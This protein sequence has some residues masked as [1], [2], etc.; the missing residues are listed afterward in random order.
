[1]DQPATI[2]QTDWRRKVWQELQPAPGRLH[3]TLRITLAVIISLILILVLQLPFASV[4]LYLVFFV[5]RD[6]PAISFRSTVALLLALIFSVSVELAV[7]ILT[8]NDPIA[9]VLSVAL[10]SYVGGSLLLSTTVPAV[11]PLFALIY[12]TLIALWENHAPAD[13]LVKGSLFIIG[14]A[15]LC[16]G[17]AVAVEYVFGSRDPVKELERERLARYNAVEKFFSL[18]ARGAPAAE[19]AAAASVVARLAVAGQSGMQ[20]LY[21][22]I[23]DRNLDTGNL[24]IGSRVRITMLAQ[25]M[26]A[27]A[28][29]AAQRLPMGSTVEEDTNARE[30]YRKIAEATHLLSPGMS[31]LRNHRDKLF[32]GTPAT[33]LERVEATLDTILAMPEDTG[34]AKVNK[35]LAALPGKK[36]PLLIP[37]AWTDRATVA[38]GLKISFCATLCY[39]IYHAVDYPGISTSVITVLI[40]G[41]STSAATNQKLILRFVGSLIGGLILGIGATTFLF[42][43]MDTITSLVILIGVVTFIAAWC[44]AAPQFGYV[45]LQIAFSFYLVAF[46]GFSAP[47]ELAPARDRLIGIL[48]AIAVMYFVFNELWPVRVISAM[49]HKLAFLLRSEV[50]LLRLASAPG[51]SAERAARIDALRDGVGK[52]MAE[53]RKLNE[54]VEYD[55][56]ADRAQEQK[57][58]TYILRAALTLVAIFWNQ[59]AVLENERDQ[60]FLSEPHLQAM[61]ERIAERLSVMADAV[62]KDSAF[63]AIDPR[64]LV[65]TSV[66]ASPRYAEHAGIATAR[67]GELQQI[68]SSL[69]AG[70]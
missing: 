14:T 61:R 5:S 28:A 23:V 36:V 57:S 8:D 68:L 7:V 35:G 58:G 11:G 69:H 32:A 13:M 52:A 42:P 38:F 19:I 47:T 31:E 49:R 21:N 67:Y 27:A 30:R 66:F 1:M 62:A 33:L 50:A 24:P 48:L 29:F 3:A 64:E 25:L 34:D 44:A 18:C 55:Y 65:D 22:T 41:L 20:K 26:E 63:A 17:S 39:V 56:G 43:H 53:I 59:L 9:R 10:V 46:E 6:S 37:G 16:M 2:Q 4:G 15:A 60:D 12:A 45:G 54:T 40:T 51:D 70:A